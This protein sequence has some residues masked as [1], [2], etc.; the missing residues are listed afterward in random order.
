ME[1]L[2]S[3]QERNGMKLEEMFLE[4]IGEGGAPL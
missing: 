3:Q 4:M 1:E 2:R